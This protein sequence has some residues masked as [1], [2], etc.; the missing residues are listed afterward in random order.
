M[1]VYV[2]ACIATFVDVMIR[3]FQYK[4]IQ[5]DHYLAAWLNSYL[6]CALN[7]ILVACVVHEQSWQMA[8]SAGIGGSFG[9]ITSMHLH[10]RLFKRREKP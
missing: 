7:V 2:V 4:N 1:T 5:G 3:A 10:S 8:L 9:V 6:M